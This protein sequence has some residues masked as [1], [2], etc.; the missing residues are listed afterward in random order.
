MPDLFP[1]TKVAMDPLQ[2]LGTRENA[3]SRFAKSLVTY[4]YSNS[5]RPTIYMHLVLVNLCI[6][7][8]RHFTQ[9]RCGNHTESSSAPSYCHLSFDVHFV[10]RVVPRT[11]VLLS[12]FHAR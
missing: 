12:H 6:G 8:L 10:T 5:F 3:R 1:Q 11:L 7:H 4:S 2:S 9:I